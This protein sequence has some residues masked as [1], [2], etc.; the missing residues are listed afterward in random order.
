MSRNGIDGVDYTKYEMESERRYYVDYFGVKLGW[1]VNKGTE[2]KPQW[3]AVLSTGDTVIGT[4]L[5]THLKR[6]LAAQTLIDRYFEKIGGDVR[7]FV[8]HDCNDNCVKQSDGY[9]VG[10]GYSVSNAFGMSEHHRS[11]NGDGVCWCGHWHE[12]NEFDSSIE[13]IEAIEQE[14]DEYMEELNNGR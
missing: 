8:Y 10:E 4:P 1:V 9:L 14:V 7:D 3:S 5:G 2:H 13:G 12:L 6:D 11:Y